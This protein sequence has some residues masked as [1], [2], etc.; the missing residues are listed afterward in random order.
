MGLVVIGVPWPYDEMFFKLIL[1][2][3]VQACEQLP[4]TGVADVETWCKLLGEDAHPSV[5]GTLR[6]GDQRDDDMLGKHHEGMIFLIGEQRWARKV[7]K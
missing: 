2:V 4:E 1:L 7:T 3:M 5:I 6:H